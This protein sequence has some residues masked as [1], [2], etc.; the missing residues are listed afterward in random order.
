MNSIIFRL[1][2]LVSFC[3]ISVFAQEKVSDKKRIGLEVVPGTSLPTW[4]GVDLGYAFLNW[5]VHFGVGYIPASYAKLIGSSAASLGGNSAYSEVIQAALRNNS[6]IKFGALYRFD[7]N[8]GWFVG[9]DYVTAKSSGEADISTVL[10]AATGRSFTTLKTALSAAG[11]SS[12]VNL[13][14]NLDLISG[15]GGYAW[16]L[17]EKIYLSCVF[18]MEKII[19][20]KVKMTTGLTTFE[21]TAVG[22]SLIKSAQS[23]LEAILAAY[24]FSPFVGAELQIRL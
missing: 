5:Q 19:G 1:F 22:Q 11:R 10:E 24:G 2:V 21:N 12:V 18:G 23:D 9:L 8:A 20:Q 13:E 14:S 17:K 3:S 4:M 15:T 7:K 6:L 16:Q